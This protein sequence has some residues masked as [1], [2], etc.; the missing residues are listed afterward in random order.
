MSSVTDYR[1]CSRPGCRAPAVATLRYNYRASRATVTSLGPGV[2]PHSWDLCGRHVE[3]LTVPSGWDLVRE[4]EAATG[5]PGILD[6]GTADTSDFTDEELQVLAEALE[7]VADAGDPGAGDPVA[8]GVVHPP[9]PAARIIRREDVPH[10][11]GRHP[12]RGNLPRH[13]PPRHL[14]AVQDAD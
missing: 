14:H 12:S 6:G 8:P 3:R 1:Q 9:T 2:D 4:D 5:V 13:T 11:S 7:A 10:P